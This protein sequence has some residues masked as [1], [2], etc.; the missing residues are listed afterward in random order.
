MAAG[1]AV[2]ALMANMLKPTETLPQKAQLQ[3]TETV[4]SNDE[5]VPATDAIQQ[6]NDEKDSTIA[7][8]TKQTKVDIAPVPVAKK[9]RWKFSAPWVVGAFISGIVLGV[10][11]DRLLFPLRNGAPASQSGIVLPPI[12]SPLRSSILPSANNTTPDGLIS[13]RV[14][15]GND[16]VEF[17]HS[18]LDIGSLVNAI[19]GDRETLMRGKSD[20]PFV[21]EI[22]YDQP[23]KLSAVGLQ[24]GLLTDCKITF[25]ATTDTGARVE[26]GDEWKNLTSE[27][28][29]TS[30]IPPN[31][32]TL[33][34]LRIEILDR[35]PP[36]G[37]GFHTHVREVLVQ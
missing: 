7:T 13:E 10:G 11:L 18:A 24:L 19:D 8:A 23:K 14:R 9:R 32:Q 6:T 30:Q 28:N 29:M 22:R 4:T 27:P 16:S 25:I 15:L 1:I 5:N 31:G 21:M 2:F 12:L 3:K 26:W 35:R 20:N 36:P 34:S 33:K 17:L 37:E